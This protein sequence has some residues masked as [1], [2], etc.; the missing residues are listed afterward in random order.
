MEKT[1]RRPSRLKRV[2]LILLACF[3]VVAMLIFVNQL[4]ALYAQFRDYHTLV[5]EDDSLITRKP[6][7]LPCWHGLQVG[8]STFDDVEAFLRDS[9]NIPSWSLS[10]KDP[11]D[12]TIGWYRPQSEDSGTFWFDDHDVL[13]FIYRNPAH[14]IFL[15]DVMEAYGEPA[16]TR[17]IFAYP[18][19][20]PLERYGLY[21]VELYYPQ[22][23]LFIQSRFE[24]EEK[25]G[26]M[27]FRVPDNPVIFSF[28]IN[29]STNE[30]RKF[31]P[32]PLPNL[33]GS[34]FDEVFKSLDFVL[35]WIGFGTTIE[36]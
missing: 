4:P 20:Y 1:K 31:L 26:E 23:G 2:I 32:S 15:R 22:Y 3:G 5:W 34:E 10:G 7:A 14:K 8:V 36:P 12:G 9:S 21:G 35:G 25:I 11:H 16:A 18:M 29:P 19:D 6:C 33:T 30:L 13:K 24:P 28:S 17:L 27:N